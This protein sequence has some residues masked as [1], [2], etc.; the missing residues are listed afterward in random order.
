M[1]KWMSKDCSHSA[2]SEKSKLT[3][4]SVQ[5][6]WFRILYKR[7]LYSFNVFLHRR[8]L[9][10]A[11]LMQGFTAL[12]GIHRL[13]CVTKVSRQGFSQDRL[14]RCKSFVFRSP[15]KGNHH[16]VTG[17]FADQEI[18]EIRICRMATA[19]LETPHFPRRGAHA[20]KKKKTNALHRPL[21]RKK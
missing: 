15:K 1:S 21:S 5:K 3:I 6:T 18:I 4:L 20:L 10:L 12:Y 8:L 13:R 14:R 11:F 16:E 2:W 7:F 17:G 19:A 9:K